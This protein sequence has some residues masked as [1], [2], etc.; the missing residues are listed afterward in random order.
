[1]SPSPPDL[2]TRARGPRGRP[3]GDAGPL[4]VYVT[5]PCERDSGRTPS[6]NVRPVTATKRRRAARSADG[7]PEGT[8]G[9]GDA[10]EGRAPAGTVTAGPAAYRARDGVGTVQIRRG[11]ALW[12]GPRG[13][14]PILT[15]VTDE[16][17]IHAGLDKENSRRR[18]TLCREECRGNGLGRGPPRGLGRLAEPIE[19]RAYSKPAARHGRSAGLCIPGVGYIVL[20]ARLVHTEPVGR[21]FTGVLVGP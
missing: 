9:V 14:A 19:K 15:S 5:T 10:P 21:A 2:A 17:H 8:G 13:H 1:M 7:T 4:C 16:W 12:A 6:W 11:A 3:R 20:L 18:K